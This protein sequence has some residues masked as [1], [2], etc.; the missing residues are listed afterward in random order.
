MTGAYVR[1]QRNGHW[2]S[3]EFD[4]LEEEEM[5][6]FLNGQ[7]AAKLLEWAVFLGGWIRDNVREQG[8]E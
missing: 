4:E 3:Y 2:D 6:D 1:I 8:D 5:R 7:D